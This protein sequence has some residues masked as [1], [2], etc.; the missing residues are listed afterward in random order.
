MEHSDDY[1]EWYYNA[2]EADE[3]EL[4]DEGV[5]L[6]E[7]PSIDGPWRSINEEY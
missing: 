6:P 3:E 4:I 1:L 2:L 5:E 7:P